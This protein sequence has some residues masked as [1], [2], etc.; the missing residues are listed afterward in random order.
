MNLQKNL[1][2]NPADV[3]DMME[4]RDHRKQ[5]QD[6][7]LQQYNTTLVSFTLNIMGAVK[8]FPWANIAFAVG[9]LQVEQALTNLPILHS[10]TWRHF[11]GNEAFFVVDAPLEV[12]KSVM[13]ALEVTHPLG[14]LFDI[15]VL[16]PSGCKISRNDL[17][18][19]ERT[20]LLC[21][22]PAFVC[23][24]SRAHSVEALLEK[25]IELISGYFQDKYPQVIGQCALNSLLFEVSVTPKPGLVDRHNNGAHRDMAVGTFHQSAAALAPYFAD[26]VMLGME[27]HHL[28]TLFVKARE[29]GLQAER[30]M[31]TAT[32][33]INTHKGTIFLMGLVCCGLGYLRGQNL[34][35]SRQALQET[36]ISMTGTLGAD[37]AG[38]DTKA[39]LTHG[40]KLYLQHGFGGARQEAMEGLPH[41]FQVGL[42]IFEQHLP[43]GLNHAG[44]LTLLHL[45]ATTDDTNILTRSNLETLVSVKAQCQAMINRT[46][47]LQRDFMEE[48]AQLDTQFITQNISPGGCADL[49]ALTHLLWQVEGLEF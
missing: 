42:P 24:R 26:F 25:T 31:L 8:D 10:E 30:A 7:L 19:P 17:G 41:L 13:V 12:V 44:A 22:N 5:T 48:I 21:Q 28:P 32:G 16:D 18:Y 36:I 43:L 34:P 38:L 35:Y 23:S 39:N 11:T 2:G 40:E 46:D 1:R 15:D 3:V 6:K 49:L 29:L 20:C 9:A 47:F 14:R 45:I 27:T 4:A 33:N 37:F